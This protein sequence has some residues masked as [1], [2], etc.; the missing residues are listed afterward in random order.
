MDHVTDSH[1]TNLSV[2]SPSK[3]SHRT[4]SSGRKRKGKKSQASIVLEEPSREDRG[5]RFNSRHSQV[6]SKKS[7]E[8][9]IL[10]KESRKS[11]NISIKSPISGRYSSPVN[12]NWLGESKFP[13]TI[14]ETASSPP[15]SS[16]KKQHLGE[17]NLRAIQTSKSPR[18]KTG[19]ASKSPKQHLA[20]SNQLSSD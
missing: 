5:F 8:G 20:I 14:K 12:S 17:M 19:V 11:I 1:A 3:N 9:F 6:N 18:R 7:S 16:M 10:S 4:K 15:R 2:N 13:S